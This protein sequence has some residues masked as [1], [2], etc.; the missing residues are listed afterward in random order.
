MLGYAGYL[1]SLEYAKDRPQGRPI[2][3]KDP[4]SDPV[5]IIQ[6]ADVRRMLLAQKAYV[7]GGLALGLTCARLVDDEIVAR[8]EGDEERANEL[9]LLLELITPIAK[10]WPSE[11]CLEAN[12]L[13]IQVLGGYGYSREYPVERFYR[14][15]RLN[16]IH[17]GTNGI[18]GLDLLGRKVTMK[19]GA[20]LRL[21]MG[22]VHKTLAAAREHERLAEDV[23][24][25]ESALERAGSTTMALGAVA[26]GGDIEGYLAN[27][28]LY[29]E[30]LGHVVIGWLW[31]KQGVVAAKALAGEV[32]ERDE[33]FYEGKLSA[34]RYFSNY[35]LPK[36]HWKGELLVEVDRTA[37]EID[38]RWF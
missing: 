1:F 33:H 31:L 4:S 17:E 13:A 2:T 23:A 3:N 18:Q 16:A 32:S 12:K 34:C 28:S 10:A 15:N 25:L 38:E 26:M 8:A 6:H 9:H 14:D 30:M 5:P 19:G 29:L 24:A 11:Y 37:L 35:E 27:A 36:V 20:G 7:E 21:L 22:E